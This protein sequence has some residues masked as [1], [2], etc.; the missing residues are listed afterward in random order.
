MR[1]TQAIT[2][3]HAACYCFAP[4]AAVS[5]DFRWV[6]YCVRFKMELLKCDTLSFRSLRPEDAELLF[7]KAF[8][9]SSVTDFLQWERHSNIQETEILVTEMVRLHIEQEKYLG[10]HIEDIGLSNANLQPLIN[11]IIH[12]I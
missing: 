9:D 1:C 7:D 2:A 11:K 6:S 5:P 10:F 3:C 12:F 4:C 8:S